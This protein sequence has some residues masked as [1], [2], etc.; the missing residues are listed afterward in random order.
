MNKKK[1]EENNVKMKQKMTRKRGE[2]RENEVGR[3]KINK[4]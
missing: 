2:W 1:R 3:E 4:K